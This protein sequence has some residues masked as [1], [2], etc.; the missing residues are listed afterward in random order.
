MVKK[1]LLKIEDPKINPHIYSH[2]IFDKGAQNTHGEKN[3][4]FNKWCWE[5][6]ISLCRRLKPDTHFSPCI[7]INSKWVTD[8]NVRPVRP[9]QLL[10]KIIGET[11]EHIGL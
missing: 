8:T 11:R 5:N 6:W 4:F 10:Q 3:R 7:N 1:K 9:L 2:L